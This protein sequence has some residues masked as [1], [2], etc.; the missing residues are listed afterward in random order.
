MDGSF[1]V[2]KVAKDLIAL[3]TNL[4]FHLTDDAPL[5]E[6]I[7]EPLWS[8]HDLVVSALAVLEERYGF[9]DDVSWVAF[10]KS[11]SSAQGR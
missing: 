7:S 10:A 4:S 3:Q 11:R 5:P 1:D 8:A 9:Q 6:I 2:E